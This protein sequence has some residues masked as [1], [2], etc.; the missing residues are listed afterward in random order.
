VDNARIA[1]EQDSY[2]DKQH[3]THYLAG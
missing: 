2:N 1:H 3:W